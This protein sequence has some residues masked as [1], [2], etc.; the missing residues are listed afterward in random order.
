MTSSQRMQRVTELVKLAMDR[1]RSE[2]AAF[3]DEACA[4]E[5]ELRGLK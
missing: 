2:Q 3:L 5:E 4:G 1:P